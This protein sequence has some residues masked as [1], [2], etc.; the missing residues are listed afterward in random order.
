MARVVIGLGSNID[1]DKNVR[2][3]VRL[4]GRCEG[5]RLEAVSPIYAAEAVGADGPDFLNAAVL[6]DTNLEP[7]ELRRRLRSIEE[8]MGRV[9]T[10]DKFA[11]RPI[12]L[13]VLLFEGFEG[14][15]DGTAIPDPGLVELA[16]LAVPAAD[17]VPE[18]EYPG[19]GRI[20][21]DLAES[22]DRE[23]LEL[24]SHEIAPTGE[25]R[26]YA[27]EDRME[28]DN[29]EVYDAEMESNVKEMLI[30]LGE[31]PDREGL[32]R[33]PLRVAKAMDFL[34]SGY[35]TSLDDAVN[36]AI[37][38][39]DADEMVIV[40]DVEFYSLCEHHMLPFFGS[41][42]VAYLPNK[43]IIGLSKIARIVDVFGRRLQVQ[44]RLTN[45][46]ADAI[47]EVLDPHGVA[48]VI[49]GSHFCMMMRGVQKQGSSMVT[50]AMRGGFK[51]N[52][53]TRSE[54]MD[55]IKD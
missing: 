46:I 11:P 8:R 47:E 19:S 15:V 22:I 34:T 36:N 43:K 21:R 25:T 1:P 23:G 2:L 53:S 27:S 4:L 28:A 32:A 18:W 52:H 35:T 24:M 38:E 9:R 12:D 54:F 55:L 5:W 6:V 50:S 20:L 33:T 49:E 51:S 44:E 45:Q 3:A 39:T 37:F 42:H 29:G 17:L 10:A 14:V 31:D 13:D 26:R 40:K 16:Y 48:V 7:A 41:A 30:G